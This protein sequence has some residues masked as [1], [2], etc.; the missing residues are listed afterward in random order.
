MTLR[1]YIG[2][3]CSSVN[4]A[5]EAL[6]NYRL[7]YLNQHMVTDE[8]NIMTPKMVDIKIGDELLSVP[9]YTLCQSSDLN[10]ED[11][12]IKGHVTVTDFED[13]SYPS[14]AKIMVKPCS[15][16]HK[17]CLEIQLKFKATPDLESENLIVEKLNTEMSKMI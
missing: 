12:I 4:R 17:D 16:H 3:I 1:E 13:A 7:D 14:D 11:V 6:S 9:Q 5:Q 2:A 10:L 8:D 15:E